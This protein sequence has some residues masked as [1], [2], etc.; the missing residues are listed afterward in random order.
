MVTNREDLETL[1]RIDERTQQLAADVNEI[2]G[3]LDTK[4]VTQ[5]EFRPVRLVVYGMVGI[6]MSGVL[7]ALGTRVLGPFK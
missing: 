6:A 3:K 2:K 5:D 1:T 7:A 4:Y